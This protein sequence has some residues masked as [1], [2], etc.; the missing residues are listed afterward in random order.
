MSNP[1]VEEQEYHDALCRFVGCIA[2]RLDGGFNDY[3]GIHHCDG[4]TKPGC[5]RFVLPLCGGHHQTGGEKAPSI[6]PW[7]RRFEAKYGTQRELNAMCNEILAKLGK[8]FFQ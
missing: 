1:T 7:T 3:V 5:Q 4:R 2:C 8:V 6:H